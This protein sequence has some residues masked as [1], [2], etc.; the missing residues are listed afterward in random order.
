MRRTADISQMSLG[1]PP[2]PW[3]KN[4]PRQLPIKFVREK[5]SK[6][7]KMSLYHEQNLTAARII[8]DEKERYGGDDAAL[9]Q[10]AQVIVDQVS[11]EGDEAFALD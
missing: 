2:T 7:R 1:K 4:V 5:K 8:L 6:R 11:R 10:W 9:V 3:R